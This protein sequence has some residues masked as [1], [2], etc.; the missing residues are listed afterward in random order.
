MTTIAPRIYVS[1]DTEYYN[2]GDDADKIIKILS[3]YLYD[4][5]RHVHCCE[6]TASVYCE[7]LYPTIVFADGVSDKERDELHDKYD[8]GWVSEGCYVYAHSVN[9]TDILDDEIYEDTEYDEA[10]EDVSDYYKC[11]SSYG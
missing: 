1:D 4:N 2:L 5:N 3:V 11:N 9:P 6:L 7:P 8:Y 10:F